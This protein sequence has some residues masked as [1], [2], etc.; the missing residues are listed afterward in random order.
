MATIAFFIKPLLLQMIEKLALNL[1]HLDIQ[2][3]M[4]RN[5]SKGGDIHGTADSRT[6]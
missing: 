5:N 4:M 6:R 3:I 1:L 2:P